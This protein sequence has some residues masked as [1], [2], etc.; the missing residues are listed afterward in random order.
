M[1]IFRKYHI[2]YIWWI[3]SI[4]VFVVHCLSWKYM[5]KCAL[6]DY[7][8]VG[9]QRAT[10]DDTRYTP[11]YC[12]VCGIYLL[13]RWYV[14]CLARVCMCNDCTVYSLSVRL[15]ITSQIHT[16]Q[17]KCRGGNSPTHTYLG[18]TSETRTNNVSS[19]NYLYIVWTRN[20]RQTF[21]NLYMNI[22]NMH[23][24][25]FLALQTFSKNRTHVDQGGQIHTRHDVWL[26]SLV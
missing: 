3:N 22:I 15:Q 1:N 12:D 7:P 11:Y 24:D 17:D 25:C 14:G 8:I 18:G 10:N 9:M 2:E 4:K 5:Y 26:S 19:T 13:R 20:K 23:D 16:P 21:A 6:S